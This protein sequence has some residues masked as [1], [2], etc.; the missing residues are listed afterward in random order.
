MP[1]KLVKTKAYKDSR[2][3]FF[4]QHNEYKMLETAVKQIERK[5]ED[6][7]PKKMKE[8]QHWPMKTALPGKQ[9]SILVISFLY[10]EPSNE[11]APVNL[12]F[13]KAILPIK[14]AEIMVQDAAKVKAELGWK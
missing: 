9:Y 1:F 12:Y 14:G 10:N 11:V 6:I 2:K 8:L 5:L 7:I 3:E 4:T 13:P